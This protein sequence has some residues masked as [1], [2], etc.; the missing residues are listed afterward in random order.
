ME[1]NF[2]CLLLS[3]PFL[4][5]VLR[6]LFHKLSRNKN[7]PPSPPS[8]PIIGHLPYLKHPLHHTLRSLSDKYGP[9]LFLQFGSQPT[10]IV[11]SLQVAEEC[12]TKNDIVLA[13]RPNWTTWKYFG[14]NFT[15]ILASNYG[16]HWRNLRKVSA[17]EIFSTHRLNVLMGIG[18]DEIRRLVQKL[19]MG[20]LQAFNRVELRSKLTE[21]AFNIMMRMVVGKRYFGDD[22]L[23]DEKSKEFRYI[24]K[25]VVT[26]S[27]ATNH[28]EFLPILRWMGYGGFNKRM[29]RLFK[30]TDVFLQGLIDEHRRKK[31]DG[32][33]IKNTM[34]DHLLSLQESEPNYYTDEIIKG[35][36]LVMLLAG[37]DTSSVTLEWALSYLVNHP[38]VLEKAKNEIDAQIGIDCLIDEPDVLKL[39]Y[40]QNI[41][42][43][44]LRLKPA[45]PLLPPH[46]ASEDWQIAGYNVP[47]NSMVLVNA[48]AILRDP[49]LWD[50]HTSFKPERFEAGPGELNKEAHKLMLPFGLGRRACPGAPLAQRVVGL[51]LGSLIQY[52]DWKRVSQDPVDLSE[53]KGLT[54]PKA[55]P[56]E[57]MC[58]ARPILHKALSGE[59]SKTIKGE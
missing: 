22:V 8:L 46:R 59:S 13:N 44:T 45:A 55:V 47:L 43:E 3:L 54:M 40:L 48:W 11:S 53:G 29:L 20:S 34:I 17:I 52:F 7:L 28:A 4:V 23:D 2:L 50:D 1:V 35:L 32:S 33:E 5:L 6:L 21:L 15:T 16:E 58:R 24:V 18:R 41:I 42:Y 19:S 10:V 27:G 9:V 57:A 14:Y 37:T 38:D 36:I 31:I 26:N 12:F 49:M 39:H 56:L 51:T 30:R 25:E